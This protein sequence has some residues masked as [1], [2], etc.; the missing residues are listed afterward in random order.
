MHDEDRFRLLR[1]HAKRLR[2]SNYQNL[3]AHLLEEAVYGELTKRHR[4]DENTFCNY[5]N[6]GRVTPG[7]RVAEHKHS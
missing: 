6:W 1:Q 4:Q 7:V 3:P 2:I 5:P